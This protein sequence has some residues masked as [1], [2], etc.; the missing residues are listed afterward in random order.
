MAD[1][2]L[3]NDCMK[4]REKRPWCSMET[5]LWHVRRQREREVTKILMSGIELPKITTEV[6]REEYEVNG[7]TLKVHIDVDQDALQFN[8]DAKFE[9]MY[10][11]H[12][13]PTGNSRSYRLSSDR[14]GRAHVFTLTYG[15]DESYRYHRN[16]LKKSKG[17][18][19]QDAVDDRRKEVKRII[20]MERGDVYDLN[21]YAECSE[22]GLYETDTFSHDDS[23][24]DIEHWIRSHL[25]FLLRSNQMKDAA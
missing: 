24:D 15:E 6:G 9:T 11:E 1:R 3:Y 25:Y 14:S 23:D 20:G 17:V 18:A 13:F 8:D 5:A 16:N 10:L 19:R 21:I 7:F 22:L 2:R 4:W 12:S